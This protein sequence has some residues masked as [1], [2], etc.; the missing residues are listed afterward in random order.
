MK[1]FIYSSFIAIIGLIV[2][3]FTLDYQ[4]AITYFI[5]ILLINILYIITTKG[6]CLTEKEKKDETLYVG[7]LPYRANENDVK[8][9]F[10][11]F[12]E[13]KSVRLM[14]DKKTGKRRGFGFVVMDS[15]EGLNKAISELNNA[16]FG[17]R[18]L[19]VREANEPKNYD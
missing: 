5:G 11:Q 2:I 10:E 4:S 14:K 3:I 15:K 13:V 12:G 9:L 18:T 8:T 6:K 16:E 19:K 1:F 7:N 17:Q